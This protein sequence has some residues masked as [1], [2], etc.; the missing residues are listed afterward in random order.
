M[1]IGHMGV[2]V[3]EVNWLIPSHATLSSQKYNIVLKYAFLP[4]LQAGNDS[5]PVYLP[6]EMARQN[7]YSGDELVGKE[8]GIQVKD[9]LTLVDA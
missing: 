8:F 5:N 9:E 1:A 4:A 3:I 7:N 6:M 2:I